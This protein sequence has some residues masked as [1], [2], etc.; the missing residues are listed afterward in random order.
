M[1]VVAWNTAVG[2][3]VGVKL[4]SVGRVFLTFFGNALVPT[5]GLRHPRNG[6]AKRR[7]RLPLSRRASPLLP[8]FEARELTR[9]LQAVANVDSAVGDGGLTPVDGARLD[10]AELSVGL[11]TRFPQDELPVVQ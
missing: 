10:A 7:H 1:G 5:W 6:S 4:T 9:S 3:N 2:D 11:G 8:E